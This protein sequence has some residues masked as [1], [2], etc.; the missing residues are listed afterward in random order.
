MDYVGS[1]GRGWALETYRSQPMLGPTVGSPLLSRK[2]FNV[3]VGLL[4][5]T[6]KS[7]KRNRIL[8]FLLVESATA[9]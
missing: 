2:V 9:E 4:Q 6:G 3:Y 7:P 8:P 1:Q 5:R